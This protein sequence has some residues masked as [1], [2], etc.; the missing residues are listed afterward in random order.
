[1]RLKLPGGSKGRK[2]WE[3]LQ[4]EVGRDKRG[5]FLRGNLRVQKG[6]DRQ[7]LPQED[8]KEKKPLSEVRRQLIMLISDLKKKNL[9]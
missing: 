4:G 1:M 8:I 3:R 6:T 5:G 9:C 7:E 2:R